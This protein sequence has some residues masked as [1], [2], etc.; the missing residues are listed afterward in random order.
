MKQELRLFLHE[1][2]QLP[3]I[4]MKKMENHIEKYLPKRVDW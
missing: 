4:F 2:K 3:H 1:D